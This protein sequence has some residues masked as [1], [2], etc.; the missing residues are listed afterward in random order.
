MRDVKEQRDAFL[1]VDVVDDSHIGKGAGLK[2]YMFSIDSNLVKSVQCLLIKESFQIHFEELQ[3]DSQ[4]SWGLRLSEDRLSSCNLYC[5]Y[6]CLII[7]FIH[8]LEF[9]SGR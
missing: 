3:S 2:R 7:P 5:S 8:H 1:V 4:R 9:K 6:E